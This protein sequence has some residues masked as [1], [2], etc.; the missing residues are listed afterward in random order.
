MDVELNFHQEELPKYQK[1]ATRTD[2][3]KNK[4]KIVLGLLS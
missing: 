2:C 3:L 4:E 1:Q